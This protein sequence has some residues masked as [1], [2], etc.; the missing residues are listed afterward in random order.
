MRYI[1]TYDDLLAEQA[2][3][4]AWLIRRTLRSCDGNLQHTAN[5][6]VMNRTRL[7]RLM[8]RAPRESDL[9]ELWVTYQAT[10]PPTSG[11]RGPRAKAS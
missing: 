9:G 1:A 8:M 11:P 4:R 5:E 7:Q 6:L 2:R 10:K 3:D